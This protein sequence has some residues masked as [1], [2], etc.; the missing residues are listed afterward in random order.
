MEKYLKSYKK[1]LNLKFPPKCERGIKQGNYIRAH[2]ILYTVDTAYLPPHNA[3]HMDILCS[4][5]LCI[6]YPRGRNL[7][8]TY[9]ANHS[10]WFYERKKVQ[11]RRSLLYLNTKISRDTLDLAGGQSRV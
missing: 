4:K 2:R 10:S 8:I 5:H 9:F 1:N 11:T 3:V 7:S 6:A